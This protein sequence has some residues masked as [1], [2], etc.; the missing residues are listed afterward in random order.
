MR[1][2]HGNIVCDY[3]LWS[4]APFW[5]TV[6][7]S[8]LSEP[9]YL[10]VG[11]GMKRIA[12]VHDAGGDPH[13]DRKVRTVLMLFRILIFGIQA[14]G[15]F[16]LKLIFADPWW[17]NVL[18]LLPIGAALL[19]AASTCIITRTYRAA[20]LAPVL[21]NVALIGVVLLVHPTR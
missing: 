19:S 7:L 9:V 4:P 13:T 20:Y 21:N 10:M 5:F 1:P 14:A 18:L 8:M 17:L 12:S 11:G 6:S 2:A 3:D 16:A 15:V